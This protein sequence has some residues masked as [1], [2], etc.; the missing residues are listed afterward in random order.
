[1]R[2]PWS[3]LTADEKSEHRRWCIENARPDVSRD[4]IE[5]VVDLLDI[6]EFDWGMRREAEERGLDPDD[7]EALRQLAAMGGMETI[8][9]LGMMKKK[10][11]D[12]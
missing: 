3:E 2:K 5:R 11:K 4:Q 9:G 10:R 12:G 7:P 8:I 1:M 6:P